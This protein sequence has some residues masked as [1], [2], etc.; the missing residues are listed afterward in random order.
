M[1]WSLETNQYEL[2]LRI[3]TALWRFWWTHGYWREGIQW[4][5]RGL[6]G[7]GN[8]VTTVRAKALTRMGWMLHKIGDN[9]HGIASL[10]Q[11]VELWRQIGDPAGLALALS[12]L[13]AIMSA[14]D[15]TTQAI[16]MLEE[17]LNIRRELSNQQG[18]YATLMNLG[19][20]VHRQ[21]EVKRA[22][23]LFEESLR[24]A[25]AAKDDYSM[26]ITL[27]NLGDALTSQGDYEHAED[28]FAEA[29]MVYQNLG[30]R[31]GIADA[32]R[33][34]GRIQL[35]L[36]NYDQAFDHLS[37]ACSVFHELDVQP[38]TLVT[39]EGLAFVSQKKKDPIKAT[40]LLSACEELR[41]QK[42][43]V[44]IPSHQADCDMYLAS[45]RVVL[46]ETV[47]TT[48][49]DEGSHMTLDHVV[50]YAIQRGHEPDLDQLD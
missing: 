50:A 22:I 11:G 16:S 24:L 14:Q 39:V 44:R 4:L 32:R 5:E 46:D 27:I 21:G 48:A 41:K 45:I 8:S 1:N 49:W 18:L 15:K 43:L 12:N 7:S 19:L 47:Y 23:D 17:A 26:S 33:G 28:C 36:G 9:T 2:L 10:E 20:A 38:L 31:T 30:D 42:K 37:N 6:A 40:R 34:R 13:G 3:A 25:R 35:K 29:E